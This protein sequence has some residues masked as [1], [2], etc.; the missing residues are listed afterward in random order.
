MTWPILWD[1]S[2]DLSRA[3]KVPGQP[4]T[5]I[6]DANGRIV[7]EVAGQT[8]EKRIASTLNRLVSS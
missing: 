5:F 8:T 7:D 6:I 4:V 2:D 1:G 3:F